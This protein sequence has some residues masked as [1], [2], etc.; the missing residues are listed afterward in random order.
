MATEE[1]K[2]KRRLLLKK[3]RKEQA[4]A[5]ALQQSLDAPEESRG[6]DDGTGAQYPVAAGS[7]VAGGAEK[8]WQ[9]RIQSARSESLPHA[10]AA[11]RE[12]VRGI[13][14]AETAKRLEAQRQ[15]DLKRARENVGEDYNVDPTA[16]PG[17]RM[18]MSGDPYSVT[19]TTQGSSQTSRP[20]DIE[21]LSNLKLNQLAEADLRKKE[22]KI[23]DRY[24]LAAEDRLE[25]EM[26]NEEEDSAAA[27][28]I[29]E[30]L[31]TSYKADL[32]ALGVETKN[33]PDIDPGRLWINNPHGKG[34]A[35]FGVAIGAFVNGFSDGKV[36]NIALQIV[37]KQVDDD[38]SAQVQN[39]RKMQMGIDTRRTLLMD[40][41]ALDKTHAQQKIAAMRRATTADRLFG[42][43]KSAERER[44]EML[45]AIAEAARLAGEMKL[46]SAEHVERLAGPLA[47]KTRTW[48]RT[49]RT[50]KGISPQQRAAAVLKVPEMKIRDALSKMPT[51]RKMLVAHLE[52]FKRSSSG[53]VIG[54]KLPNTISARMKARAEIL[55]THLRNMVEVGPM[56]QHDIERW[57]KVIVPKVFT[58][59]AQ[60]TSLVS[61][62]M[63]DSFAN[64]RA[65]IDTN[66]PYRDML[67]AKRMY[68]VSKKRYGKYLGGGKR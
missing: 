23:L 32:K 50:T 7:A 11:E 9:P 15:A 16:Q 35:D 55:A 38:I 20:V 34:M 31:N 30:E 44:R 2:K 67:P 51:V 43:K 14:D 59:N 18:A 42:L 28:K 54:S 62:L 58:S 36:A 24:S 48:S 21:H 41:L 61:G 17:S 60:M 53:H 56:T 68:N 46:I 8:P 10:S 1:E 47:P 3:K 49:T 39:L 19:N 65:V 22:H 6:V 64:E 12:E 25:H 45:P 26:L 66:A 63:Q 29:Q 13:D 40:Q 37:N 52:D 5:A 57:M 4:E 27:A 33:L